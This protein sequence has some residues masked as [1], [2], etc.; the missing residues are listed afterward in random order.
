M[1]LHNLATIMTPNFFRPFEIT[2]NDLI[3]AGHLVEVLK[4]M[5]VHF[6]YIFETQIEAN[7]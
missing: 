1:T 2:P 5:C 3:Y 7:N 4:L 6:E